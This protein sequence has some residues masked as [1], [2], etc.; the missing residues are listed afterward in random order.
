M[1]RLTAFRD[2][3]PAIS[4]DYQVLKDRGGEKL[5]GWRDS[6]VAGRQHEAFSG[7]LAAARSGS[8]RKDFVVAA[9]AVRGTGVANPHLLEVGCGS[10][11]YSEVLPL[12]LGQPVRYVGVDY[13]V[14][15]VRLASRSYPSESFVA[16]DA[17]RLPFPDRAFDVVLS[18]TSL[19]HIAQYELAIRET[20][21]VS[22]GWCVF[23][24][25][26]VMDR[27]STTFLQKRA[28]GE[29]VVEV[30]FNR[31]ELEGCFARHGLRIEAVHES[32]PYDVSAVMNEPTWTLTY[33][34][35]AR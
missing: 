11:Y 9:A 1:R 26:P 2:R 13:S 16:G 25:V 23:H 27:R 17:C 32:I 20:T 19:M 18:G 12:L 6:Q 28:Y 33:L 14:E 31:S 29:P 30:I 34:C 10:G 22:D 5:D 15:M 4:S 8:P 24:T 35:R 21:R 7:L 3:A